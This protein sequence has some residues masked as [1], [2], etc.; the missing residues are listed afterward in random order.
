LHYALPEE[1][2][3]MSNKLNSID[4]IANDA[5]QQKAFPGCQILAAKNG[6]VFYSKSFGYFTYDSIRK[7]QNTDIYDLASLTKIVATVPS[8]MQLYDQ[9]EI[10]LKSKMSSYLHELKKTNKKDLTLID[11]LTHQAQLQPYIPFYLNTIEPLNSGEKV[12]SD[13]PNDIYPVKLA[14][15]RYMNK[16]I[17]YR[18]GLYTKLQDIEH[19][20]HV[21]DYMYLT[22]RY[23]DS[24]FTRIDKSE[25]LPV[26][27]YKYSDL[28]FY[29]LY[30]MIERITKTS[31]SEYVENNFYSKLGATTLGYLPLNQF[32]LDRIVPTENDLLFRRQLIQGYVHDQGASMLGGV[33]GHAGVFSNANDLAKLMQLYLNKGT[34]GGEEFFKSSTLDY[35]TSCPFCS[36]GN[37]RGI[38]FDKPDM[39]SSNG[40]TCQ[41]VSAKSFGHS[42]FTGT[43]T[44]ADPET[45]IL[46][47]F[48]SNRVYPD[49]SINKLVELNVR[50]KILEELVKAIQN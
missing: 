40:P 20:I 32:E 14:V 26:K 22:N 49:A 27:Q 37:R 50:T 8:V 38:G 23:I 18:N 30:R 6:V 12:F 17:K 46:Y 10:K 33:C 44:W 4:S 36:L 21:A 25:L 35:F 31:L 11:M 39:T 16:S 48:L 43:Y 24:I 7:V 15:N 1:I 29:Y 45:G 2:G 3:I 5:I 19:G 42:G 28:G 9:G 41:C 47:I 13:K 34:Y